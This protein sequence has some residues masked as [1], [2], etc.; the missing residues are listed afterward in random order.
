[1]V[2]ELRMMASQ[3]AETCQFTDAENLSRAA[4]LLE[5]RH[6]TPVPAGM[7]PVEYWDIDSGARIV[8]EPSEEAPGGCWVV[9]NSRHV[10]PLT[11]FPTAKAA[12]NALQQAHALLLP[13]GEVE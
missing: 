2:A 8:T 7:F 4:D 6:P 1:M 5:Q 12:W 3:A 13:A 11:E 9:L 10:N